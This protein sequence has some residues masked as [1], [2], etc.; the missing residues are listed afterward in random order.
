MLDVDRERQDIP[1]ST[2]ASIDVVGLDRQFDGPSVLTG[3]DLRVRPGE[4]VAIVG[5]S[6][7]G[8]STLLRL[9]AGLDAP[10][11]DSIEIDHQPVETAK[12]KLRIM[13]Q[14]PRLLPWPA[15]AETCW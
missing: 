8:K 11:A 10:T 6:G 9:I 2:S 14:E 3:V 4:F 1:A 12:G 13:F 5:K 7:C 15:S